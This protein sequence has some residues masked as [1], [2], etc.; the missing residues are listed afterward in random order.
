MDLKILNKMTYGLYIISSSVGNEG[1]G[2]IGNTVFQVSANP[3]TVG[4]SINKNN[5]THQYILD[6]NHFAVSILSIDT[7]LE[8]IRHF[9]F[10]SG[11]DLNKCPGVNYKK[12]ISGAHFIMDNT[13]GY[14]ECQVI[15]TLDAVTHTIFLGK[16]IASETIREGESLTYSFYRELVKAKQS[17]KPSNPK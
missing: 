8:F 1:N 10:K 9:S 15:N 4:V 6:S 2:M 11:R 5:L 16:V 12:G 13:L 14:L 7:P 17:S 3:P